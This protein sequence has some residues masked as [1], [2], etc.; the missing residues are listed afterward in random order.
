[1]DW[2]LGNRYKADERD[3]SE[4]IAWDDHKIRFCVEYCRDKDVLDLGCVQHDPANYQSKY[5]LHKALRSVSRSIVGM[6]LYEDGVSY[7]S[8]LGY[9]VVAGNAEHFDLGRQFDVIVCGDL[10]EHLQNLH[11]LLES[12]KRHLR[13][14]GYLL[15]S[16]P[17]PWYWRNVAKA[18]LHGRVSNN[19]EHTMWLCPVTLSQLVSRHGMQVERVC[20]GS[21]YLRDRVIP[22]PK[23]I[24]HTSFHAAVKATKP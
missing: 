20:F 14:D 18:F 4:S 22:L 9:D 1:M 3:F 13:R 24:K 17:N 11:G 19:P 5:W 16:T 6:D 21:R 7:L 15:I 10:I 8:S 2:I 12:C 23:G